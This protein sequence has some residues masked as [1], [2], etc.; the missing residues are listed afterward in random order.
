MRR[1]A[2]VDGNHR[3]IVAALRAAGALVVDLSAAGKGVPDLL[4]GWRSTWV[5][6]EVKD[7]D[8]A[9]SAQALTPEQRAFHAVAATR[10][11]PCYVVRD[12]AEALDML[13]GGGA[14]VAGGAA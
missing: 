2:K 11:L 13:P 6:F 9:P 3:K 8:K 1:A 10:R 4:V 7:G 14:R 12:V 5:L